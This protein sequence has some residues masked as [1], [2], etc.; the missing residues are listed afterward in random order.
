MNLFERRMLLGL[1]CIGALTI[2]CAGSLGLALLMGSGRGAD[3]L[4]SSRGRLESLSLTEPTAEVDQASS[5][6]K[7][8]ARISRPAPSA[9][10]RPDL[11]LRGSAGAP[12]DLSQ[13]YRAVNP[14]VVA[15]DIEQVVNLGSQGQGRARGSGS[16]WIYD[17]EGHIVTNKH[18]AGDA[19]S[20]EVVFSDGSRRRAQ[21]V[22]TDGYSDLAVLKVEGLPEGASPLPVLEDLESL[23]VGQPVVAIGNPFGKANSM[24][25]G[26]IS[27]LGRVIPAM[28]PSQVQPGG[29]NYSI[30]QTIQTDAAINPGN[31]GGPLLDLSGQVIGVNAQIETVNIQAGGVPGNSGV[32]F[33]IPASVVNKVVPQ[34]I[35]QG[36]ARWS[37]LGIMGASE[38]TVDLA[39]ANN[40]AEPRGAYVSGVQADG[41]SAGI[42]R[43]ASNAND[44]NAEAP[45]GGDV[46]IAIDGQPVEDFD[47]LLT[48]V[49]LETVPGQEVRLT[50]LRDG[51]EQELSVTVGERP[52]RD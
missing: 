22:G 18:V 21:V 13:V 3:L 30:P 41:P 46:I 12:A 15:I 6:A 34:L 20:L 32:G 42:L 39:E 49:A 25:A 11:P 31:S 27:A 16:G 17:T 51:Q 45:V 1:G 14:G 5:A 48:Y 2:L 9:A 35:E 38:F 47:D 28:D 4:Q 24:T 26:I 50:L 23:S 44:P 8:P 36:R 40:L 52:N 29:S 10:A 7:A 19:S 33:A 37:Y 43:G